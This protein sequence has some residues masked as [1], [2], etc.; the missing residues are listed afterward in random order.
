MRDNFIFRVYANEILC[1]TFHYNSMIRT[2]PF[3]DFTVFIISV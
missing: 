2:A 1:F 3:I